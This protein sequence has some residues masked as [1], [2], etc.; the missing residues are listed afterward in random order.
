[1]G[2]PA[3]YRK[4][5][6]RTYRVSEDHERRVDEL[7]KMMRMPSKSDVIEHAV[8]ELADR[9]RRGGPRP[10][11][12]AASLPPPQK[13]WSRSRYRPIAAAAEYLGIT[14]M[15]LRIRVK[16][17]TIPFIKDGTR[18]RFDT[19]DL[20]AYMAARRVSTADEVRAEVSTR[21][22]RLMKKP[23]PSPRRPRPP[24]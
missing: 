8:I 21:W 11:H 6:M 18:L 23:R 1:M 20:D 3:K 13:D 22:D 7:R 14:V 19:R 12:Q 10:N 2:R 9:E 16:R 17:R 24:Q 15:A 5:L 4:P